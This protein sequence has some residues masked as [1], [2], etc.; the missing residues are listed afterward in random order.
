MQPGRQHLLQQPAR[1]FHMWHAVLNR[2]S[3]KMIAGD[4]VVSDRNGQV[5][6]PRQGPRFAGWLVEIQDAYQAE[7]RTEHRAKCAVEGRLIENSQH[8][9][10]DSK[11]ISDTDDRIARTADDPAAFLLACE[12]EF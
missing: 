8:L 6:V 7:L 4:L 1:S 9:G 5:L 11:Q 3:S 2:W 10:P 12:L